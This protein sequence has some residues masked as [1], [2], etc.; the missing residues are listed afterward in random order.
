MITNLIMNLFDLNNLKLIII[1]FQTILH[2]KAE[3]IKKIIKKT[4]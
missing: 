2:D 1:F 3:E 4:V